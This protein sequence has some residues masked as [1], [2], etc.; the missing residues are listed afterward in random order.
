MLLHSQRSI[1]SLSLSFFNEE[2]NRD[3]LTLRRVNSGDAVCFLWPDHMGD[4]YK[5]SVM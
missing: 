1:S 5:E 3:F 4:S 2:R